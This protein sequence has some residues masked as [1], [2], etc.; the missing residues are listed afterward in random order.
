VLCQSPLTLREGFAAVFPWTYWSSSETGNGT[1]WQQDFAT[2]YLTSSKP[3]S[4]GPK[5]FEYYV[6][7][8]RAF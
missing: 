8:I 3:K 6:R 7:P 2:K 5:S 4:D 1:A